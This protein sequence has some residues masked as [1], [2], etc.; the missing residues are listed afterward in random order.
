MKTS[1]CPICK[2]PLGPD[3]HH[4]AQDAREPLRRGAT[5]KIRV[6]LPK[7]IRQKG[8]QR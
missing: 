4:S 2:K 5:T 6:M 7:K 3:H 1:L 8:Q